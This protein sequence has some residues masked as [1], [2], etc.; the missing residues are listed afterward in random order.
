MAVFKEFNLKQH[1][2]TKHN[3]FESTL[4]EDIWGQIAEIQGKN[5]HAF[6]HQYHD[7]WHR[8]CLDEKKSILWHVKAYFETGRICMDSKMDL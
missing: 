8:D 2:Q 6:R 7:G 4:T 1:F 3:G 5:T